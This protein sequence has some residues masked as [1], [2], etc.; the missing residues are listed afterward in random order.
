MDRGNRG[1]QGLWIPAAL[2]MDASLGLLEKAIIADVLSFDTYY[3]SNAKMAEFFGVT[4]R[5]I[6]QTVKE[7]E[8][9]DLV[10]RVNTAA[11]S[12]R[13]LG[14]VIKLSQVYHQKLYPRPFPEM[15]AGRGEMAA[16]RGEE[17][18]A[19]GVKEI[20]PGGEESFALYIK[21]TDE[22]TERDTIA[23]Y[24]SSHS[25]TLEKVG[26]EEG[27]E[28][29]GKEEEGEEEEGEEMKYFHEPTQEEVEKYVRGRGYQI[30]A[31][32]WWQF[33][34]KRHFM[35]N[36][37]RIMDWRKCLDRWEERNEAKGADELPAPDVGFDFVG[38]M[39]D[40]NAGY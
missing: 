5:R 11:Q 22:N 4:E 38:A 17:N 23:S 34:E 13:T 31:K 24:S 15:A 29:E 26:K 37:R 21:N 1:F 2:W 39:R 30:D 40:G 33:Y 9:K 27:K 7:M 35:A 14:R 8:E 18:F 10:V 19:P 16:G 6:Q 20:S 12:G 32:E 25:G 3:K 28:E 36:G